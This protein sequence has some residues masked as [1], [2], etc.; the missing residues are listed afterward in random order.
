MTTGTAQSWF[1]SSSRPPQLA[2]FITF[3][4]RSLTHGSIEPRTGT[5]LFLQNP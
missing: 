2:A 4:N 3:N 1:K 5:P